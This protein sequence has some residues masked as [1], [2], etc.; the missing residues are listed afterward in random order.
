MAKLIKLGNE[1]GI[2]RG[3][4][5]GLE[6]AL[7]S[8]LGIAVKVPESEAV[9]AVSLW[10]VSGSG[11]VPSGESVGVA[12]GIVV[13][14][15]ERVG[16]ER[17]AAFL[18]A[19]P[20]E[21]VEFFDARREEAVGRLGAGFGKLVGIESEARF[22]IAGCLALTERIWDSGGIDLMAE[23]EVEEVEGLGV[24]SGFAVVECEIK[25]GLGIVAGAA[26]EGGEVVF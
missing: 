26:E 9:V 19:G 1:A 3:E 17:V 16:G 7:V 23:V 2:V 4:F 13:V 11:E 14:I 5:D 12:A 6:V 8:A 25:D 20:L 10:V 15:P 18:V 22:E 24:E 21:E